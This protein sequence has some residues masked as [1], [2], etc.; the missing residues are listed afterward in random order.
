M[1]DSVSSERMMRP[2]PAPMDARIA[3]SC[4]RVVHCAIIRIAAFAQAIRS[5][6]RTQ[7][8]RR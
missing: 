4:S 3:I 2:R 1:I 5:V 8:P 6:S 7:T